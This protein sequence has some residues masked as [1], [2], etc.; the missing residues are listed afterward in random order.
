MK[1]NQEQAL[2]FVSATMPL[3]LALP[4]NTIGQST[5][6]TTNISNNQVVQCVCADTFSEAGCHACTD[7]QCPTASI[8]AQLQS[9]KGCTDVDI[10]CGRACNLYFS[11]LCNCLKGTAHNCE[12]SGKWWLENSHFLITTIDQVAGILQLG[13]DNGGWQF[14]QT[15]LAGGVSQGGSTFKRDVGTLAVNS[16][17]TRDQ[18]QIHIHVCNNPGSKLRSY[19]SSATRGQYQT[20]TQIPDDITGAFPKGTVFCQ[21]SQAKGASNMDVA[22]ITTDYVNSLH[23]AC[24]KDNVGAGLIT[25]NNDYSWVCITTGSHAAEQLFCDTS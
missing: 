16:V 11:A 18:E 13:S 23:T 5:C 20:L 1:I 22:R 10:N 14:G 7:P 9:C 25:D 17:N 12:N 8:K 3:M 4:S 2:K 21:A 24:E 15:L 6:D 19:L